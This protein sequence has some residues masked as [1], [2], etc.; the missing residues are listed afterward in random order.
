M[1]LT[2][3]IRL[4]QPIDLPTIK[5]LFFELHEYNSSFDHNFALNPQWEDSFENHV[6]KPSFCHQGVIVAEV[7][8]EVCGLLMLKEHVDSPSLFQY[9][10]WVEVQALYIKP[11]FRREGIG[12]QLL[13]YAKN[14][15]S[16]N[17][18][19]WLQLYVT[20][21]NTSA[22]KFYQHQGFQPVQQ[23]WRTSI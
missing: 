13:E 1:L 8:T 23:I 21:A 15:C 5:E 22:Q 2:P 10:K 7:K 20:S 11:T 9:K 12:D 18:H 14:W 16:L 3:T 6:C 4:A 19:D 17:G